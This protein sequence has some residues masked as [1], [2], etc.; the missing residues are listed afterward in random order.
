MYRLFNQLVLTG[1]ATILFV[2][3]G[4]VFAANSH[5]IVNKHLEHHVHEVDASFDFSSNSANKSKY[6]SVKFDLTYLGYFSPYFAV[7]PEFSVISIHD[8]N[9]SYTKTTWTLGPKATFSFF[10]FNESKFIPYIGALVAYGKSTS[11]G[12][13]NKSI[14]ILPE[15]ELGSKFVL[16]NN[17]FFRIS[18]YYARR[19]FKGSRTYNTIGIDGGFGF[20][21]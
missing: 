2:A 5:K 11:S 9:N 21:F 15:I 6:S 1:V 19:I 3:T 4:T 13:S 12:S 20:I 8:I 17:A 10:T 7:G 18:P 16:S 14:F